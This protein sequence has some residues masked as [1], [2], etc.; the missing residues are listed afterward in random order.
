[1][2]LERRLDGEEGLNSEG[3]TQPDWNGMYTLEQAG[4]ASIH[5][6]TST[7]TEL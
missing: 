6:N 4:G 7:N 5:F 3:P 2:S 1:M